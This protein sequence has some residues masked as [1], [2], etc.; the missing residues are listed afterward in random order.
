MHGGQEIPV[1]LWDSAGQEAL[2]QI[3][4]AEYPGTDVILFVH[5]MMNQTSLENVLQVWHPEMEEAGLVPS[6]C[7]LVGTKYDR[8]E[9]ETGL[10]DTD[11]YDHL[12]QAHQVA[13]EIG[14][15]Q[16]LSTSAK[17]GYGISE[18]DENDQALR[19]VILSNFLPSN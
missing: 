11:F 8:F 4:M 9:Q 5:D 3:R 16:I 14:A 18:M 13:D 1:Q 12:Q 6:V 19:Q 15:V 17:T 7:L 10:H 2:K